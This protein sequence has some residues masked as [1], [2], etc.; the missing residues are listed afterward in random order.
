MIWSISR[1]AASLIAVACVTLAVPAAQAQELGQILN[2]S[3][4]K[5]DL[6]ERQKA[7][8]EQLLAEPDN[9][10]VMFAYAKVSIE[11]E[12]YEA[13]ISTLERLLIYRQDIPLIRLE[14][15]VAYFNLGSYEVAKLY[16][17]LVDLI[18]HRDQL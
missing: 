1:L 7:L 3:E 16:F 6:R 2:A 15:A 8:F 17:D 4:A 18:I 5:R 10:D 14:L 9:I 11:L 13:A 12:D